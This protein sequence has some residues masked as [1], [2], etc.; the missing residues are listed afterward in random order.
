LCCT[1]G[2]KESL[3]SKKKTVVQKGAEKKIFT[4]SVAS[5]GFAS[6]VNIEQ[7]AETSPPPAYDRSPQ[8]GK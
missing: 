7:K 4:Q 6:R 3:K 2:W 1:I 8:R 5:K